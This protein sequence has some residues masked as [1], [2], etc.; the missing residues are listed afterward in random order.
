M[1]GLHFQEF[2]KHLEAKN[3]VSIHE[4]DATIVEEM[5]LIKNNNDPRHFQ[6]SKEFSDIL[7][8]YTDY[9]NDTIEG[10]HGMTA[11][12]W[13]NFV[14]YMNVYHELVRSMREGDLELY[15]CCLPDF[16]SLFFGLNH[17][18]YARWCTRY[19]DNLLKMSETHPTVYEE[20]RNVFFAIQ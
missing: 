20:F 11:Q 19:H 3:G 7:V 8:Q 5:K 12:F 18:N 17:Q 13:I 16:N 6:L 1:E 14:C 2:E 15:I 4:I 9:K 10:K